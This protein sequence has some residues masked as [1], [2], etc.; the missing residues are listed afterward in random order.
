MNLLIQK[1]QFF[2]FDGNK[3]I[4]LPRATSA[5]INNEIQINDLELFF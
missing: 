2:I 1:F 5:Q 3:I 4:N